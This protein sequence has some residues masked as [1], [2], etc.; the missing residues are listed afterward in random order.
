[1]CHYNRNAHNVAFHI[2]SYRTLN[3]FYKLLVII[4]I[5]NENKRIGHISNTVSKLLVAFFQEKLKTCRNSN[6]TIFRRPP[7]S[8]DMQVIFIS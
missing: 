7:F 5:D 8:D 3:N 1:M 2:F 4:V 6:L